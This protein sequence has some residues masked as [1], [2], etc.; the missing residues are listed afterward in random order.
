MAE[1]AMN[2]LRKHAPKVLLVG[3]GATVVVLAIVLKDKVRH[4]PKEINQY[5]TM[6]YGQL[7]QWLEEHVGSTERYAI[8]KE[9]PETTFQ[10]VNL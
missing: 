9:L 5:T 2:F 10:I 6:D 1:R 8:F 7:L 3:A 4:I